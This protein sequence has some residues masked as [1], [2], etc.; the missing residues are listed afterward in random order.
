MY[1][2]TK[3]I[4]IKKEILNYLD[5]Q[6]NYISTTQLS[7][8]LKHTDLSVSTLYKLCNELKDEIQSIY[9]EEQMQLVISLRHGLRLKR[10]NASFQPIIENL[11]VKDPFYIILNEVFQNK[12]FKTAHFCI[13]FHMSESQ[14]RRRVKQI[15]QLLNHH[16]LHIS[17]SKNVTLRGDEYRCRYFYFQIL[18]F[19]HQEFGNI[20]WIDRP[21]HYLDGLD[22]VMEKLDLSITEEKQAVLAIW[23]YVNDFPKQRVHL[24]KETKH[25]LSIYPSSTRPASMV[26]WGEDDWLFFTFFLYSSNLF[27]INLS[28]ETTTSHYDSVKP[29]ID[30]WIHTFANHY[31]V[32][33]DAYEEVAD[34]LI[35]KYL[36]YDKLFASDSWIFLD[37]NEIFFEHIK[38]NFP[39][40]YKIFSQFYRKYEENDFTKHEKLGIRESFMICTNLIAI[41]A[42]LPNIHIYLYSGHDRIAHSLIKNKIQAYFS[43]RAILQFDNQLNQPD[44]LITTSNA[45][46][47]KIETVVI[48]HDITK[49]DI[50]SIEDKINHLLYSKYA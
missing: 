23:F 17:V 6:S 30:L 20:T 5:Q 8:A 45:H 7:E 34:H 11:F 46:S 43:N 33:S 14:L 42:Y 1:R 49:N 22:K 12:Q 2:I 9:P 39:N 38:Q 32:P 27:D 10:N 44:L 31:Q 28:F 19:V 13:K 4:W 21:Q 40:Y 24:S 16:R 41:D 36:L 37:S 50:S 15:N 48:D 26:H 25:L 29:S 47:D 18:L 3:N 35:Y